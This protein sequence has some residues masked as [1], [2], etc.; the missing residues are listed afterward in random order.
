MTAIPVVSW[1]DHDLAVLENETVHGWNRCD[2]GVA[3]GVHCPV[4]V[5]LCGVS[6]VALCSHGRVVRLT[7][8]ESDDPSSNPAQCSFFFFLFFFS[9]SLNWLGQTYAQLN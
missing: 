1:S 5:C 6:A 7:V 8:C 4:Y 2:I 3:I 9:F